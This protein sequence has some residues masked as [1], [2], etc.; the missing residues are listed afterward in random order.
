MDVWNVVLS[1]IYRS[2]HVHIRLLNPENSL[3]LQFF[4]TSLHLRL[5]KVSKF[6]EE[7]ITTNMHKCE[8][9]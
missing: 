8:I 9:I 5:F 1:S 4:W 3:P 6:T 2:V 7:M